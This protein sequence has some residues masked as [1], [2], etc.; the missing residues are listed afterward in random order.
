ILAR[1]KVNDGADRLHLVG[2]RLSYAD[3]S[4]FQLVE[5]CLYA[6]PHATSAAL[7]DA[8]LVLRL[9][10]EVARNRRLAL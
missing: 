1:N 3:L 9:H 4:L 8:P 10:D 5:G 7:D 2:G 6:F